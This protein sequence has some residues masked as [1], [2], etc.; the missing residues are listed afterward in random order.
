MN[1]LLY[2]KVGAGKTAAAAE[3]V[4]TGVWLGKAEAFESAFTYTGCDRGKVKIV[5]AVD[6]EA[7]VKGVRDNAAAIRERG[8]IIDDVSLA[9]GQTFQ[10]MKVGVKNQ[11][12]VWGMVMDVTVQLMAALEEARP[13]NVVFT[14]HLNEPQYTDDGALVSSGG[15]KISGQSLTQIAGKSNVF[16]LVDGNEPYHKYA[17]ISRDGKGYTARARHEGWPTAVPV[18]MAAILQTAGVTVPETPRRAKLWPLVEKIAPLFPSVPGVALVKTA[19]QKALAE[20]SGLGENEVRWALIN[21]ATLARCRAP[22]DPT[23]IAP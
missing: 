21:A 12:Q 9:V 22:F 5:P 23:L 14:G 7:F 16:G 3:V 15:P 8:V 10:R 19:N 4:P 1:I 20:C 17:F 2:G 6:L 18:G 11:M 13:L